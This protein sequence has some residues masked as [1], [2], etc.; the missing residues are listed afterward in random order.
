LEQR[1]E[2][3]EQDLRI[4]DLSPASVVPIYLYAEPTCGKR[5]FPIDE[6]QNQRPDLR[7][8]RYDAGRHRFPERVAGGWSANRNKKSRL[9]KEF[10]E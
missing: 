2:I 8:T 1:A 10:Q 5:T 7:N 6:E 9:T 3:C 4:V